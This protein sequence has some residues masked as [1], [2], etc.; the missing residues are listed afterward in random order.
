MDCTSDRGDDLHLEVDWNMHDFAFD[1]A[2]KTSWGIEY[3]A[4]IKEER[5]RGIVTIM[6]GGIERGKDAQ[7]FRLI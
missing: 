7:L 5:S 2:Y 3:I 4:K 1:T 6:K